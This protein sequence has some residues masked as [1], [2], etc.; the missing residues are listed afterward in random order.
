MF[1]F[2]RQSTCDAALRQVAIAKQAIRKL[3]AEIARTGVMLTTYRER[4][5]ILGR[6][7]SNLI[8]ENHR[9]TA[10]LKVFT[11]RR[12][13]AKLNL[14]QFRKPTNGAAAQAVANA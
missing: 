6:Q 10:E 13:K 5:G 12:D 4:E 2:V 11:D 7:N 14:R 8:A 9:L 3:N 1:G